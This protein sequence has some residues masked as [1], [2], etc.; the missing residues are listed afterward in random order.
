MNLS[1]RRVLV[2]GGAGFIGSNLVDVLLEL[3]CEVRVLDDLSAGRAENVD[4]AVDLRQGDIRDAA[5]VRSALHDV[6]VVFH[7]AVSNLRVSLS[8]SWASHDVNAGGT[9]VVLEAAR[10]AAIARFVYCSSSEVYGTARC[11]PMNEQHPL[12]PTTVY[13]A[14]KLAGEGYARA[15]HRTMGVPAVVVRPF[16][17]YGYREHLEGPSGEVIPRMT[18]RALNGV[19]PVIFGDGSQSRDFMFVTDTARGLIACAECDDAVG[20]TLNIARGR[21]TTIAELARKICE[22]AGAQVDPIFEGPRP[23]DVHR[24]WADASRVREVTGFEAEVDVDEGLQRFVDWFRGE[25]PDP[26]ALLD[27]QVTRNWA[28]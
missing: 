9:L 4:P 12:E 7:L 19:P 21:E 23:G 26:G 17:T 3:G 16:N 13:G 22:I 18:L 2:T 11:L 24:Q 1:G 28:K 27:R 10:D 8:D 15:F 5:A 6:D 25:Y 20:E 14:S